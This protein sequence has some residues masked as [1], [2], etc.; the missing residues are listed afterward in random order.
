MAE[1]LLPNEPGRMK[2]IIILPVGAMDQEAIDTLREN[3]IC[4]VEAKDPAAVT[5]LDP[6]PCISSRTEVEN[7][8]IQLSRKVL[9]PGY[10]TN[11]DTRKTIAGTFLDILVKGTALDPRPSRAEQERQ[12]FDT[13][14]A[15]ELRRL[16][17]EEAKAERIAAKAKKP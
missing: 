2:P 3:G 8:A 14:K 16:A 15:D 13:A 9:G 6:I 5:F 1:T 7:A 4:V 11:E 10:W 12:I 17:R